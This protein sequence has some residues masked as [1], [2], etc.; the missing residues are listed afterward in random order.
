MVKVTK[1][2]VSDPVA[3]CQDNPSGYVDAAVFVK[4]VPTPGRDKRPDGTFTS[5]GTARGWSKTL[6]TKSAE[7]PL[8]RK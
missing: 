5:A 4:R 1:T 7:T 3:K 6:G 8:R 2:Y